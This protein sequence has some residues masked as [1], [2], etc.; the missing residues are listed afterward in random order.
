MLPR[1]HCHDRRGHH[2][3]KFIGQLPEWSVEIV[4]GGPDFWGETIHSQRRVLIGDHLDQG[5]RR[6]VL[7]HE[8]THV[9]HG[10]QPRAR[11]LH[12]EL[13]ADRNA[14]LLLLPSVRRIGHA[15]AWHRADHDAAA[16]DLWVS[17][18]LF[19]VRLSLLTTAER[20]HLHEQMATILV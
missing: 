17:D 8:T 19:S 13:E 6:S 9:L 15:L 11:R 4:D 1:H 2:P 16:E 10:P 5:E 18:R 12:E 3:W 20:D 14:A 7:A